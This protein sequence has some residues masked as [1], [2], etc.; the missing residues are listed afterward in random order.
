MTIPQIEHNCRFGAV[1]DIM[2]HGRIAE[3]IERSHNHLLPWALVGDHLKNCDLLFGNLE[4]MITKSRNAEHGTSGKYFSLPKTGRALKQIGF[5]VLNLANNHCYDWGPE[6]I[7]CTLSELNSVGIK[8]GGVG[9]SEQ[10]ARAPVLTHCPTCGKRF[11]YLF[12][13]GTYN[14]VDPTHNWVTASPSPG[15]LKSDITSVLQLCDVLVVSIHG[16]ACMNHWPSPDMLKACRLA[17]DLGASIVL[18]HH[19]HVPQG[20]ERWKNSIIF[21]GL[22]DFVRPVPLD[23]DEVYTGMERNAYQSFIATMDVGSSQVVD[24]KITPCILDDSLQTRPAEEHEASEIMRHIENLSE[25]ITVG[26]SDKLH[27]HHAST[28]FSKAYSKSLWRSFKMG[29]LPWFWRRLKTAKLHHFK[30][31]LYSALNRIRA[32]GSKKS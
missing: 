28:N 25:D 17:A 2:L 14:T 15:S 30:I 16:G 20:I 32:T 8:W 21:Y 23:D 1:G 19:S 3:W 5:D 7:E 22:P 6:G 9:V 4:T 31:L 12:Y 26:R 24:W 29:G 10:Q 18:G 11:G 13:S 27:L